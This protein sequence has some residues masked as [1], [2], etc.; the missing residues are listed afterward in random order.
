MEDKIIVSNRAAL[1][2]KYGAAGLTEIKTAV[3]ALIAAD[4][5]R[6]IKS[7]FVYL[8]DPVAMK[9]FRGR[10]VNDRTSTRQ[11]KDAIDAIFRAANPE[12]LMILGAVRYRL[13]LGHVDMVLGDERLN[14][15]TTPPAVLIRSDQPIVQ[16]AGLQPL[17]QGAPGPAVVSSRVIIHELLD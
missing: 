3:D 10:A 8:D 15:A 11:N 14:L 16:P 5:E 2:A 4:A 7:R 12:Y 17:G 9:R 13:E 6:G 1:T